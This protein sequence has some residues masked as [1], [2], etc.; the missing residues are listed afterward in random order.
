MILVT[1]ATGHL[2]SAIVAQLLEKIP[3]NEIVGLARSKEKA[4]VL[5]EKGVRISI[6]NLDDAASLKKA[7]EGIEKIV[8]ISTIDH[9]RYQQHKNLIDAAKKSG[10]KHI[11]YTSAY[12][13][14]V[15][16]SPVK[17][18]L[19]SHFQTED[20]LKERGL[21]YSI[22]RNSLYMD[23][24]PV[25]VSDK[26]FEEGI[27][28]PAGDGKVAYALRREMGEAIANELVQNNGENKNYE[29]TGAELYSYEDIAQALTELSGKEITYTNADPVKFSE[30][31]KQLGVPE[32]MVMVASG[33]TT[34]I[35][36]HQY[37]IISNDLEYLLG[38]KPAL[39]KQALQ[40]LYV[41]QLFK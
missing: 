27:F 3:A 21:T 12:I 20:Y 38:R 2:G 40:E 22:F 34:D 6:G 9:H 36:N 4:E 33:F 18:H 1:G 28:L 10:V 15:A 32:R 17:A 24:I 35:R 26:V 7:T 13:K 29:L 14:D 41:T 16:T 11:A 19:E 30:I 25:Y 39:L 8:L 5:R 37:E 23:M 31:L